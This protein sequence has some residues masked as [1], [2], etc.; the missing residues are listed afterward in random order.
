VVD[1]LDFY[2]GNFHWPAFNVA[3]MAITLGAIGLVLTEWFGQPK[4]QA[5]SQ[6]AL[7]EVQTPTVNT[8]H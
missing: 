1:F 8:R 7:P 6:Q 3:D 4:T 2:W 5:S